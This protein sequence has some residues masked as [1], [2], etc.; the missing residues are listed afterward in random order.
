M[1]I[2]RSNTAS[3]AFHNSDDRRDPPK[4]HP[5]TREAVI[6]DIMDWVT[7]VDRK[8]QF[9]WIYG[10]A[11]TGKS[12]IA[13]T[14]AEICEEQGRL[15]S[16]FFFARTVPGRNIHTHLIPTLAYQ[17]T[18]SIP[19]LREY[20]TEAI[21][22]DRLIFTRS[23]PTQLDAVI[24]KPLAQLVF[25][26]KAEEESR[27]KPYPNLIIIDGL[28][29]CDGPESQSYVLSSFSSSLKA[30]PVPL[31]FL[32]ASR[33]EYAIRVAFN[34]DLHERTRRLVLDEK[35]H[36][37]EDIRLYLNSKFDE[38]KRMHPLASS[39]PADWPA[40]SDIDC[41]VQN[42]SGQFIYASTVVKFIKSHRDRPNK[43]LDIVLKLCPPGSHMPF[44]DL[45]A[46]YR[47]ILLSLEPSMIE[48]VL[49]LFAFLF[50][51]AKMNSEDIGLGS[52]Q[53][54]DFIER[55]LGYESG[56][57]LLSLADLHSIVDVPIPQQSLSGY[58]DPQ[59]KFRS[60]FHRNAPNAR[61]LRLFHASLGDF[62]LDKGRSGSLY[63]DM[64]DYYTRFA[65][66]CMIYLN[67]L[68]RSKA[69]NTINEELLH[70]LSK[71][72]MDLFFGSAFHHRG[73]AFT[74][75]PRLFHWAKTKKHDLYEMFTNQYSSEIKSRL[76]TNHGVPQYV[77][78]GVALCINMA[79]DDWKQQDMIDVEKTS[80]LR[81]PVTKT[82]L[83]LSNNMPLLFSHQTLDREPW[84]ITDGHVM[85]IIFDAIVHLQV[86][87]QL[88]SPEIWIQKTYFLGINWLGSDP[89]GVDHYFRLVHVLTQADYWIGSPG[90][91]DNANY[92]VDSRKVSDFAI[93]LFDILS[94]QK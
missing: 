81:M 76:S 30:I 19:D 70:E 33:P 89:I 54:P 69:I 27:I 18:L 11:G 17:L 26:N 85:P 28:D 53:T 72:P 39:I 65:I 56:E 77:L 49:S 7:N 67:P 35:Y 4:C 57:L 74:L 86:V 66:R 93:A 13:Q 64:E 59:R 32:I 84:T 62:L 24:L 43:R 25:S 83:P 12:S 88:L 6:K 63:I 91:V 10:P 29:E 68:L 38:I 1:E 87:C 16:D 80:G 14:I 42:A 90:T 92:L 44:A 75:V 52:V 5:H 48:T 47:H 31:I 22:S 79:L 73:Q 46:L 8:E 2:L 61:P 37:D 50:A 15:A 55:F 71:F 78:T 34:G 9:C 60:A 40:I 3:G 21:K 82:D 20:I 36:P 94:N 23:L 45:D 51:T 41:I 58:P